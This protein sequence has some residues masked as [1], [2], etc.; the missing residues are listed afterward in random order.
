MSTGKKEKKVV[1][2]K[3]AEMEKDIELRKKE[4]RYFT[5][6]ANSFD[7]EDLGNLVGEGLTYPDG[8]LLYCR[9]GNIEIY[10]KYHIGKYQHES[11]FYIEALV[12]IILKFKSRIWHSLN[13]SIK[14]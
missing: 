9:S 4:G 8:V 7:G 5:M 12:F 2:R 13:I 3:M 10:L 1:G 11:N 14:K 6:Q